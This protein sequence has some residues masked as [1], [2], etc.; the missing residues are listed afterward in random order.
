VPRETTSLDRLTNVLEPEIFL[1][2]ACE[3]FA[4]KTYLRQFAKR[5]LEF[6]S[7]R[8]KIKVLDRP[9]GEENNSAPNH[10]L[11]QLKDFKAEHSATDSDLCWMVVDKDRW[12]KLP[13]IISI[14]RELGFNH[15]VSTPSFELWCLTHCIDL[16]EL[17]DDTI[18]RVQ[19]NKKETKKR[20]LEIKLSEEMRRLGFGAFKKEQTYEFHN[21]MFESS[22][23][24]LAMD[25]CKFF[26]KR[27]RELQQDYIYP[28]I[29]GSQMYLLL[30]DFRAY[31]EENR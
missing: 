4:E 28:K 3:G 26:E 16:R 13:E 12:Q 7:V 30:Q 29:L 18:E 5:Y 31:L 24:A 10:V 19:R 25:Q 22:K 1:I 8:H 11:K 21:D 27:E 15:A 6:Q 23:I 14:C 17:K 2:V 9:E 20:F